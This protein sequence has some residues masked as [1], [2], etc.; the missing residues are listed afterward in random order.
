MERKRE[1][2][3]GMEKVRNLEIERDAERERGIERRIWGNRKKE[4][5]TEKENY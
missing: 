2:V 5:E 3:R 4:R 1:R